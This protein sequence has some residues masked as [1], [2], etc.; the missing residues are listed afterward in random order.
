[1]V[2]GKV[3]R[4]GVPHKGATG[5]L[6]LL[7]AFIV[8]GYGW[9][10]WGSH[11]PYAEF[12]QGGVGPSIST[13][14]WIA[15]W[16][17]SLGR[18]KSFLSRDGKYAYFTTAKFITPDRG[19]WGRR[20]GVGPFL[21]RLEIAT[22]MMETWPVPA[23]MSLRYLNCVASETALILIER[24]AN[25]N[26]T[27]RDSTL[28]EGG[29]GHSY[30]DGRYVLF[31]Y[32]SPDELIL[33]D[34]SIDTWISIEVSFGS[35]FISADEKKI[36]VIPREAVN[37]EGILYHRTPRITGDTRVLY[38]IATG[39]TRTVTRPEDVPIYYPPRVVS[40]PDPPK[41]RLYRFFP[42]HEAHV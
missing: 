30:G 40:D 6:G 26:S 16:D 41:W 9:Y 29:A 13:V 27:G 20:W 37:A 15:G 39:E 34:R 25:R 11:V 36:I 1:M 32:R 7:V 31:R 19:A 22:G 12:H 42:K 10:W 8:G 3:P 23:G 4:G 38:D 24:Y 5:C 33:F 28:R 35:A 21:G 17:R 18:N 2:E 14:G